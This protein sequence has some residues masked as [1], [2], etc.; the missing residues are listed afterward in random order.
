[1]K[2]VMRLCGVAIV[3][4]ALPACATVTRGTKETYHIVSTPPG[5]EV[6]LS[7]GETCTT[8]CAIKMKRKNGFTVSVT[9]A[10]Y[11]PVEAKVKP[12]L[13]AG[14]G[15][16]AAGN[17]LVGGIIGG[18]VDGS[19]G[20]MLDLTPN[21]LKVELTPLSSDSAPAVDAASAAPLS[22]S[23]MAAQPS[24]DPAAMSTTQ[25]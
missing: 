24:S 23:D 4:L 1:M 18:I 12:K 3:T 19:N 13:K 5:A 2:S 22:G 21:P 10:G 9:K 20:S 15:T 17:V 6:A 16:A 14:G 8:P 25:P 11:A 7:S